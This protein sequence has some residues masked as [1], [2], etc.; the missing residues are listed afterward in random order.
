[1]LVKLNATAWVLF[2]IDGKLFAREPYP[3]GRRKHPRMMELEG[4]QDFIPYIEAEIKELETNPK[5]YDSIE[6][7]N[8]GKFGGFGGMQYSI[9]Q[10]Y[11]HVYERFYEP[12]KELLKDMKQGK[13]FRELN[14]K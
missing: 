13:P 1:M 2:N 9:S 6:H 8:K 12:L 3:T 11:R 7:Y 5:F 10:E 4:Q 14:I